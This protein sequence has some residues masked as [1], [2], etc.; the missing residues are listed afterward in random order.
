MN[1]QALINYATSE[2]MNFKVSE[3]EYGD[4]LVGVEWKNNSVYY[5]FRELMD[6]SLFFVERYSMRNGTSKVG[7]CMVACNIEKTVEGK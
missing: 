3:N 2:G 1:A 6:G 5:W 7:F 4:K